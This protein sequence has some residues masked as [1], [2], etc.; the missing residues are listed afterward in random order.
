[1]NLIGLLGR[2]LGSWGI[3]GKE[4]EDLSEITKML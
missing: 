4:I 2:Y 1:M 3:W